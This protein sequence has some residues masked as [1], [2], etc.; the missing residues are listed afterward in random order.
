MKK[1]LVFLCMVM[2]LNVI[3]GCNKTHTEI[4]T[5]NSVYSLSEN[6]KKEYYKLNQE[7]MGYNLYKPSADEYFIQLPKDAEIDNKVPEAC[8]IRI[9]NP[10]RGRILISKGKAADNRK[11]NNIDELKDYNSK[12]S[13][14]LEGELLL[15]ELDNV[16]GKY[17]SYS[18]LQNLG[19]NTGK[20]Y[21]YY[22]TDDELCYG[23]TADVT[24]I[25][26]ESLD[27]IKSCV[28]SFEV[29]TK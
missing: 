24:D 27:I 7:I 19:D 22:F 15:F 4:T 23:I 29:I 12:S 20:Y 21:R 10:Y 13:S 11:F 1:I 2:I 3:T 5:D 14:K 9:Q 25:S 8:I 28:N 6:D 18:F 26:G 17:I 16:D